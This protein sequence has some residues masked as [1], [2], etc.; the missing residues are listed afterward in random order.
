[1][2]ISSVPVW[3]YVYDLRGSL[4]RKLV[5]NSRMPGMYT[6]EWNAV[7]DTGR[8]VSSSMYLYKLQARDFLKT[9]KMLL[10]R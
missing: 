5:D 9:R 6:M 2:M 10:M 8:Q 4:V 1:M 3:M 7:D